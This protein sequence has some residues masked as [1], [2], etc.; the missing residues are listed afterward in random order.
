MATT[1][2]QAVNKVL[3]RVGEISSVSP[4][5]ASLTDSARQVQIDKAVALWQECLEYLQGF[6]DLP[7]DVGSGTVTLVTG[8]REYAAASGFQGFVGD[9]RGNVFLVCADPVYS[10]QEYPG[11]YVQ[12]FVDQPDPDMFDGQP[13]AFAY[14]PVTEMIRLDR[15]P[16]AEENGQILSYLFDKALS[17]AAGSDVIPLPDAAVVMLSS[18]VAEV[19][20]LDTKGRLTG[21]NVWR[22][23]LSEAI[24]IASLKA[25]DRAYA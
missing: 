22:T 12:M 21:P 11:G 24:R 20:R 19:Y 9:A 10:I 7:Q 18:T 8:T 13:S 6:A 23:G 5:L 15:T 17:V 4:D 1:L 3:R 25:K 2:L 16:T 14:N